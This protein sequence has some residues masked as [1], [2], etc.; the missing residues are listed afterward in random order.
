MIRGWSGGRRRWPAIWVGL[1]ASV[2]AH[3]L[4]AMFM[5]T[6]VPDVPF[7]PPP[8]TEDSPDPRWVDALRVV[9]IPEEALPEEGQQSS[10]APGEPAAAPEA[11]LPSPRPVPAGEAPAA[12][13]PGE[14]LTNAERLRPRVGDPRLWARAP[15]DSLAPGLADRYDR[16]ETAVRRLLRTYLD[17]LEL[18]EEQERRAREWVVGEGDEKWGISPEGLHLGDVTIPI[19]FGQMLSQSGEARRQAEQVLRTWEMIQFQ[20]GRL[21]AQEVRE[22]RLEAIRERTRERLRGAADGG[23]ADSSSRDT[24]RR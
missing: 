1:A 16:A 12:E 18:S 11:G 7:A 9:Q 15:V 14:E 3:L 22:E 5:L 21:E 2:A 17:S 4:L 8:E 13:A 6:G 10:E 19:P 20:A 23:G 24:T